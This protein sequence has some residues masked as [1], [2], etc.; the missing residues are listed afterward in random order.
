MSHEG[1]ILPSFFQWKVSNVSISDLTARPLHLPFCF[2]HALL[3]FSSGLNESTE[4]LSLPISRLCRRNRGGELRVLLVLTHV[5]F[6]RLTGHFPSASSLFL[7]GTFAHLSHHSNSPCSGCLQDLFLFSPFT[8]LPVCRS[9]LV[10]KD[11]RLSYNPFLF[12]G[13]FNTNNDFSS[14]YALEFPWFWKI[15]E[16]QRKLNN[17]STMKM[18]SVSYLAWIIFVR[19]HFCKGKS[20]PLTSWPWRAI[21]PCAPAICFPE[22]EG[23]II[24]L[25]HLNRGIALPSQRAR[26][27]SLSKCFI[28]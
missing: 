26:G 2:L 27:S 10:F 13:I 21:N 8:L 12:F 3:C 4:D 15:K 11:H 20:G 17:S 7:D 16:V 19:R 9:V 1:L 24:G 28:L 18:L 23:E 6:H 22:L 14:V 5:G 25:W